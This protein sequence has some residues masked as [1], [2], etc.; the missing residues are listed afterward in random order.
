MS[1]FS[2]LECSV[3]CAAGPFDPRVEQHLCRCGAPLLARYDLDAARAW[4]RDSLAGRDASMWR[5]RE[6]MPL[7]DGEAPLTLGEGWTPL[8]HAK[9]LGAE[10]GMDRLF[11][12]DESLNPTNSFKARGLAAAVTRAMYLGATTLSVPSA[13]NAANALAA[14]AAAAG[15]PAKVFMPRDVKVPFIRECELYGADVTLVDG[16]ITDAGR[17]AAEIG[18]PLGWYDVSTLKE[19]Y[20][21]E[22]KKTMA[23]ELGEQLHWNF[24]DWIVYPTGGGTGMVGMW[25]AFEEMERIGWKTPGRRPR[26]VSVQAEHCAPIVKAFA[27]GAERSEMWQNAHTVADGLRVPKAIGDFLVLRAIRESGGTAVTATDAQMVAAMRS[28]GRS[29]GISAAPEGG[30]ALH[31]LDALLEDGRVK[32]SDTVVLFNTGGALKYLDALDAA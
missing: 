29:E 14:Y 23:Y 1:F 28:L 26:M 22:G 18:R 9:R 31:A 20:R 8:I 30:A 5:Y 13:G 4:T 32:R 6:L 11:V 17:I 24:P 21:I 25:K 2:H 19:P 7:F 27:Q 12:K 3:P 10:R 15:I 16:L